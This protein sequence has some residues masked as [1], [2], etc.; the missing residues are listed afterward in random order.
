MTTPTPPRFA[1]GDDVMV[2]NTAGEVVHRR[3]RVIY[4]EWAQAAEVTVMATG[5]VLTDHPPAWWYDVG[6]E[7]LTGECA[8]RPIPPESEARRTAEREVVA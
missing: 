3:R 2:V 4:R 1:V 7:K 6:R 5:Q 8:L